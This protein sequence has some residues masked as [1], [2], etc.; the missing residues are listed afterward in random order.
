M[1]KNLKLY[2]TFKVAPFAARP[3]PRPG[4]PPE[5]E[6]TVLREAYDLSR[7]LLPPYDPPPLLPPP[8]LLEDE[9]FAVNFAFRR[10]YRRAATRFLSAVVRD[11]A[12][13]NRTSRRKYSV[14]SRTVVVV[15]VDGPATRL[16]PS[17]ISRSS[18]DLSG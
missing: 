4:P 16:A 10:F 15:V 11:P 12:D 7:L 14:R 9:E 13:V 3:R 17:F 18:P 5:G 1:F 2:L 6:R 8:P